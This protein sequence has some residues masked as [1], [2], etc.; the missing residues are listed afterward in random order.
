MDEALTMQ[1][2]CERRPFKTFSHD[3][4]PAAPV[5]LQTQT[6]LKQSMAWHVH[7]RGTPPQ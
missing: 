6:P 3:R 7:A 4:G 5:T 1:V 2:E